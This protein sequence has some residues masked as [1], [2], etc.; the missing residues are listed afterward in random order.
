MTLFNV[1]TKSIN[2][3][4]LLMGMA[5]V[6]AGTAAA[7]LHGNLEVL[8]AILC[9]LFA[10]FSQGASNLAHRYMDE[11]TNSGENIDD[12]ISGTGES[13]FPTRVILKEG[14]ISLTLLAM[15]IGCS[16]ATMTGWWAFALGILIFIIGW[17]TN[18]GPMLV[19]TPWSLV[20]TFLL[21]GPI[22][23]MGTSLVQSLHEATDP[24]GWYDLSPAIYLSGVMG[25]MAVNC[26]ITYNFATYHNDIR[27]D[28][29]TFSI[30]FGRK[31]A[32]ILF[33]ANGLLWLG[34]ML[35]MCLTL[36]PERWGLDMIAPAISLV[37]NIYMEGD[38][39]HIA[40]SGDTAYRHEHSQHCDHG[41][42]DLDIFP[43]HG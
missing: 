41:G 36:H 12:D 13:G 9:L 23:V 16:L 17:F 7:G 15:M 19:R 10:I 28:K 1:I 27:N 38:A 2:A 22:G 25:L 29:K 35:A 18:A 26:H 30:V 40:L 21:F 33:I 5:T 42:S 34:L 31:A 3:E 32:R 43:C 24:L 4:S 11:C 37:I 14:F 39:C 6:F 8:P 20:S